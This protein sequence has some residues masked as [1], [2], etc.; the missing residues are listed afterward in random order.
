MTKNNI[1]IVRLLNNIAKKTFCFKMFTLGD[2]YEKISHQNIFQL[3]KL[4]LRSK[5]T[6]TRKKL[7]RGKYI[8]IFLIRLKNLMRFPSLPRDFHF[9][10]RSRKK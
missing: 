8:N 6:K 9:Y 10:F 4:F 5:T 2:F 7:K 3:H 1:S